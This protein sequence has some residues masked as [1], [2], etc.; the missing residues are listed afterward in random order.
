ML[1]L[2][3]MPLLSTMLT[4]TP[5]KAGFHSTRS[6][7]LPTSTEPTR[8]AMPCATAGLMVYLAM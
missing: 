4:L 7:S 3:A 1:A 5:K 8:C 6:A 2:T